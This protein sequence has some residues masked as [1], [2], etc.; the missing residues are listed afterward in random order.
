[1][2]LQELVERYCFHD[3]YLKS[4]QF[5]SFKKTLTISIH[6]C[7]WMQSYYQASMEKLILINLIFSNINYFECD[8]PEKYDWRYT[9]F[10]LT[11]TSDPSYGD[12]I[13]IVLFHDDSG[14][15]SIIRIFAQDVEFVELGPDND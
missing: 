14:E 13:E 7:N 6:F 2:K 15:M 4:V 5:D 9:I 11:S 8:S 3:S 1:M 12:G 10:D